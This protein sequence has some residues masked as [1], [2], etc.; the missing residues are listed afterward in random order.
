MPVQTGIFFALISIDSSRI[1]A[2]EY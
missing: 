2:N 1:I